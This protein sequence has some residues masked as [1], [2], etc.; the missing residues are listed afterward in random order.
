MSAT[1]PVQAVAEALSKHWRD[2]HTN[3]SLGLQRMLARHAI[4]AAR[5]AIE[6]EAKVA[7]L[8]EAAESFVERLGPIGHPWA[9]DLRADADRIE[10]E[11]RA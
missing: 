11:G 9:S 7:A 5:P 6:R 8:R 2:R 10:R 1:D 4:D 3:E